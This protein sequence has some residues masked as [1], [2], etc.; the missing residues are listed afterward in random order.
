MLFAQLTQPVRNLI[1][2]VMLLPSISVT[3]AAFLAHK[4]HVRIQRSFEGIMHSRDVEKL[5]YQ[6]VADVVQVEAGQRGYLLTGRLSYLEPFASA[7][8]TVTSDLAD[9][10]QKVLSYPA[11]RERLERIDALIADKLETASQTIALEN[12]GQHA[13]AVKLVRADQNK[14]TLETIRAVANEMAEHEQQ[15]LV[16]P[17][18]ELSTRSQYHARVLYALLALNSVSIGCIFILLKSLTKLKSIVRM[19]AW[20]RTIEYEGEW[21]SFERYLERR[22]NIDITHG[23]SPPEAEKLARN[24]SRASANGD[25]R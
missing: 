21:I 9:L 16:V 23:I 10:R 3:V 22:F 17:Q 1:L 6:L 4:D 13:A 15:L 24:L 12:T 5:V 14:K 11:Q 18:H 25:E 7:R 2:L 8:S 19:C 20:S